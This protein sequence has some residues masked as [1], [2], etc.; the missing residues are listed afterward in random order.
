MEFLST[1]RVFDVKDI[2]VVRPLVCLVL[3]AFLRLS[4]SFAD[5]DELPIGLA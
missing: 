5:E 4:P 2:A 1:L 3:L